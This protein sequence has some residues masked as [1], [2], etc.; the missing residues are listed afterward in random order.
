MTRNKLI[1]RSAVLIDGTGTLAVKNAEILVEDGVIR[2]VGRSGEHPA[3]DCKIVDFGQST[4]LPGLIDTHVHLQFDAGKT[5]EGIIRRQVAATDAQLAMRALS[6]AQSALA[7]GVTTLRDCGG[8][9]ALNVQVRE[10]IDSGRAPGPRLL[11]SGAPVTTTSGHLHWCGLTADSED[12]VRVAVRRMVVAGVDFIKVMATGGGMTPI[13]NLKRPQYT[14]Q[15]LTALVEDANRL[16]KRVAAHT[17]GADGCEFAIDAGVNTFEHFRWTGDDGLDYRPD[18][19]DRMN[20]E[21]QSINATYTGF[22]R[23]RFD[24]PDSLDAVPS[25]LIEELRDEYAFYRDAESRGVSVTSS[26]DAGV[27]NVDFADFALSV[28]AGMVALDDTPEGAIRRS[29]SAQAKSLG[30]EAEIGSIAPGRRA[31]LL[32]VEGDASQNIFALRNPRCVYQDGG[33]VAKAGRLLTMRA[34]D[35]VRD[36]D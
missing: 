27:A 24:G 10:A 29:T 33:E 22:D 20:P 23:G 35:S 13:S 12:E 8:R 26:S 17:L 3:T 36:C 9:M 5:T 21:T 1:L 4:I 25:Q 18:A 11:V 16:N 32:V 34:S 6:H 28:I 2:G 14:L 19:I 15:A 7:A 30:L 31:D